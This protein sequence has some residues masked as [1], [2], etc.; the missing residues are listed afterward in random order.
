M[1]EICSCVVAL[2]GD[3][4]Q[5]VP[6][7]IVTVPEILLLQSIHGGD[8]VTNIIITGTEKITDDKI[9]DDLG[10]LYKDEVVNAL[11]GNFNDLPKTLVEAKIGD[12]LLDP[13]WK[14]N[15]KHEAKKAAP[16]KKTKTRARDSS[17]H[18]IADDPSTPDV[19]EA[20]VEG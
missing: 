10:I 1:Y 18:F 16:K 12:E 6:K 5:T 2:G 9:R 19:N 13:V 8:A 4:R 11:F 15:R 7:P 20:Y 3:V 14:T 17:G